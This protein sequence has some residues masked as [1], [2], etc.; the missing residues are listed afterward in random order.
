[1]IEKSV[2][3]DIKGRRYI[4]TPAKY[5]FSDLG[6]RNARL[7]FRQTEET[8]LMENLIYNELRLRGYS[9]DVGQVTL[10]TK[11]EEGKSERK[12]L[13]VDFVCN[14]GFDRVYVQ[15]AFALNSD[16]KI[17][18]EIVIFLNFK[19]QTCGI[20]FH[21]MQVD[22]T[23]LWVRYKEMGHKNKTDLIEMA[24]ISTN[25]LAKLT[26]GEFVSMESLKKICAALNCDVG[27][28]CTINKVKE[29]D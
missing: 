10:N 15:S 4:D 1:M 18:C 28:V 13:E 8:H 21:I 14:K 2:R 22:Y 11:N 9:V 27:D 17:F 23:K 26:K 25:I 20:I 12:N 6:L 24:G 29:E 5:Y 19:T 7:S 3:Y 16:E